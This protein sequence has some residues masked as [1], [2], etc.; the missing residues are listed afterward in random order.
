MNQEPLPQI[1]L[2]RDTDLSVFAYELHIFAG[3]F[4]RECEFNMRSLATN[5]GADSIAIMGK[6]HMWLSD[7]LF[8]YCSTADLHQMILTTE[9]I[10]ARAFLFHTD[11]SEGGHLYGDV[12]MMDLDTLRQDIKRNILYPCGVNIE[13]KDGSAATVSLLGCAPQDWD[14]CTSAAPEQTEACFAADRTILTGARYGTVTVV[15]GGVPYEITTFRAEAGYADSRHP[16]R[17]D[18]LRELA[19]DL[20][21]RDF[22][23]NA[24]AADAA[25]AVTD[26][27]GGQDDLRRG[28][29][30]CVGDPAERF[31]EDALRMLR[32]LRFA[33]RLSFRIDGETAAAIHAARTR[34]RAVAPERLHKEL[35]GILCGRQAAALLE[36]FSDVLFELIP[37]LAPCQGFRQ[38]NPHHT[39]DVWTHTLA[40]VD[41][42]PPEEPLRL[43]ALLHDA[44]KP[45]TFFFDKNLVGHFYGHPAAGAAVTEEV[46]RRLRYDRATT[47]F[48]TQLVAVHGR[49]IP[50]DLRGMR[51]MLARLGAPV[52]RALIQL[53]CADAIGTGTADAAEQTARCEAA[54]SL[55]AQ[56]EK[57]C[58]SVSTLAVS[59]RDLLALG[60]TQG[61]AVGA[62]LK[63]L[64]DAVLDGSAPNDRASLLKLASEIGNN[65]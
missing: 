3:D 64:L 14:I 59:G 47:E 19:P 38:Y 45:A 2:I 27:F 56:A 41:G 17:V 37:E 40:V 46:L 7:A 11:R 43:A 42:V 10:G 44:G 48:V 6:N 25:G 55:L 16:D 26:L 58:S 32:A 20:A 9:F 15:R 22:T 61:P 39:R 50:D 62:V 31:A 24:M 1:H 23:V 13:R 52:C 57:G 30:R 18:F 5:T 63:R 29:I 54:L 49:P 8:A 34:L 33:A 36:E 53:R 28:V 35:S 51:R 60:M 12:L 65:A 4:L 21:R